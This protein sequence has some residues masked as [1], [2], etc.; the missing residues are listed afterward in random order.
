M[1]EETIVYETY[2]GH[3]SYGEVRFIDG[4]YHCYTTPLFGGDWILEKKFDNKQ[5]AIDFINS[6]T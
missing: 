3:E 4:I 6:I 2:Y 5:E 1:K